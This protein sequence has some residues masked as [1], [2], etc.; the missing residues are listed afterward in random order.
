MEIAEQTK[1]ECPKAWCH[2]LV[3]AHRGAIMLRFSSMNT[4]TLTQNQMHANTQKSLGGL[5]NH[6]APESNHPQVGLSSE[7]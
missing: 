2:S 7:R 4:Y 5:M 1:A 6:C 3:R